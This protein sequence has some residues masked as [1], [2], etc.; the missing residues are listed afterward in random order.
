[1][2]FAH[3]LKPLQCGSSILAS[4]TS[5]V[6]NFFAYFLAILHIFCYTVTKNEAQR[7]KEV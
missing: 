1:V 5:I 2:F 6:K 7:G 4:E 3:Q